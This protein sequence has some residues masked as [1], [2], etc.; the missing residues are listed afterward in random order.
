M[1]IGRM[2]SPAIATHAALTKTHGVATAIQDTAPLATHEAAKTAV[3][4]VAGAYLAKTSQS[5]QTLSDT[6]I[7]A[8]IA[9]DQEVVDAIAFHAGIAT[10][11]QNAPAL[12]ATHKD[13]A[14]AHH[15]PPATRTIVSGTYAGNDTDN[16]QITTG[17]KCSLVILC[18]SLGAT[19]IVI[20]TALAID[21]S[22]GMADMTDAELHAT[23]GF[24]VDQT[25]MNMSGVT[26]YYW[27][28][29]E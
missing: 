19:R 25:A 24:V 23:D 11:H 4:A 10:A 6:E 1:K 14:N 26:Y 7:P 3:H 20:P 13:D 8:A 12:I 29:S 17:F 15:T 5:D 16:R 18:Q 28:I 22:D 27:A 2:I 21:V 9:R